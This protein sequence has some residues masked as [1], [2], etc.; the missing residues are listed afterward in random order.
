MGMFSSRILA[1]RIMGDEWMNLATAMIARPA[2]A[3]CCAPPKH[4]IYNSRQKRMA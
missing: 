2:R 4:G 1:G 3:S